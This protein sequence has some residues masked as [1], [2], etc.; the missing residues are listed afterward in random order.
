[1]ALIERQALIVG[2]SSKS[3]KSR[4]ITRLLY[5]WNRK[6]MRK[7]LYFMM[8][9]T[10]AERIAGNC[11]EIKW[12]RNYK[13]IYVETETMCKL[14]I[15]A[16][17]ENVKLFPNCRKRALNPPMVDKKWEDKLQCAF[18]SRIDYQKGV[19]LI[20]EIAQ[21]TPD[22][23]YVF[24]GPIGQEYYNEFNNA[25]KQN[26]NLSYKG[27]F[28]GSNEEIYNELKKYDVLLFPTRWKNE[29]VPGILV[30]AKM[31]GLAIIASDQ[32]Y[33]AEIVRDGVEGIILKENSSINLLDA[34]CKLNEDRDF[35]KYLKENS[36]A[37]SEKFCV[38]NYINEILSALKIPGGV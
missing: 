8:G 36:Y 37:S 31:A 17:L 29:G 32:S 13:R 35:L 20:L 33:N 6:T 7:S 34:V 23:N 2:V 1:M 3:G 18:F 25:V 30:E 4:M 9:G 38:E 14:L 26:R 24:Y 15:D 22:I 27:I 21:K 12:Y 19:D 16:G 5:R 10:E 11:K 28:K